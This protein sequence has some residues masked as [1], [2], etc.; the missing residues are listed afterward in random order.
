MA[1]TLGLSAKS[2]RVWANAFEMAESIG[3]WLDRAT[4]ISLDHDLFLPDG[5]SDAWGDGKVVARMLAARR[6]IAP[7]IVHTSNRD[8]ARSM[9]EIL[10][11]GGWSVFRVAPIGSGGLRRIGH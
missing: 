2:V 6:P 7:V 11:D 1:A 3:D 8:G 10:E 4:L 5:T 9:M